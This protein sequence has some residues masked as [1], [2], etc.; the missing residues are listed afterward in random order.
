MPRVEIYEQYVVIEIDNLLIRMER[1]VQNKK[2]KNK[3]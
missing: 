1:P 2:E 3:W